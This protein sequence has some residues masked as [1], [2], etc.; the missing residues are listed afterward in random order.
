[1]GIRLPRLAWAAA[2]LLVVSLTNAARG[3]IIIIRPVS[4]IAP[5]VSNIRV[6]T[7][8]AVP[9]G[10]AV[11]VGSFAQASEGRI[12][13]GVPILGGIPYLGRGFRNVAY[14]RAFSSGRV[15]LSVRIIDIAEEEYRQTGI[16]SR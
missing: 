1:M 6:Q 12:E 11:T 2:L 9:D 8:V 4:T 7:A 10:G 5:P 15:I 13:A 14:G 3:Q 16:R